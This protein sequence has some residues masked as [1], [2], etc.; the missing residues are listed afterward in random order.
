MYFINVKDNYGVATDIF[1]PEEP[2]LF[3]LGSTHI[4]EIFESFDTECC[5]ILEKIIYDNSGNLY[6]LKH[7]VYIVIT[8]N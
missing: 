4:Y 5:E 3:I 8:Q 1:N 6:K 2:E 7:H